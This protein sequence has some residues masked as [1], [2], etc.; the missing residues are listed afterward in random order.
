MNKDLMIELAGL[1][2]Q[3]GKFIAACLDQVAENIE[4]QVES[5]DS[6]AGG[7]ASPKRT[8]RRRRA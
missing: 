6:D 5:D 8:V 4:L 2:R 3:A 7:D 1:L